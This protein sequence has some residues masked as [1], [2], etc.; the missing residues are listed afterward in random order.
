MDENVDELEKAIK[1][2]G[3]IS[4]RQE[5]PRDDNEEEEDVKDSDNKPSDTTKEASDKLSRLLKNVM[6]AKVMKIV[7][8]DEFS[9]VALFLVSQCSSPVNIVSIM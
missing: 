6:Q 5:V 8:G 3:T 4:E 2:I 9:L 1:V 7:D